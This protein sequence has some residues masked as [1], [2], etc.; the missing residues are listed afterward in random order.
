MPGAAVT[1]TIQNYID[2]IK[3]LAY[4]PEDLWCVQLKSADPII[5]KVVL[6]ALHQDMY[7]AQWR[8][9]K[10]NNAEAVLAAVGCQFSRQ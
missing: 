5:P 8:V 10:L 3:P 6:F 9:H 4:P 7:T 2:V 1:Y